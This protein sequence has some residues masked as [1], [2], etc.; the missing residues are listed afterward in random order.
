MNIS[1]IKENSAIIDCKKNKTHVMIVAA[2]SAIRNELIGLIESES[3]FEVCAQ[4]E[5][6]D[7]VSKAFEEKQ[8][9]FTII[10]TF[11]QDQKSDELVKEIKF[12]R[13]NLPMLMFSMSK[14]LLTKGQ[15]LQ[16][17]EN[18]IKQKQVEEIIESIHY[19][20]NLLKNNISGFAVLVN[21]E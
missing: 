9:D 3:D 5:S 19:V 14:E 4:V 8:I 1:N 17:V 11:P 20:Q 7:E 6:I 15:S 13:P 10:C 12:G 18:I 16:Q 21:V 2:K